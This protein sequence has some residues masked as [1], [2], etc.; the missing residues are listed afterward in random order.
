MKK[1][2]LIISWILKINI[3]IQVLYLLFF[4]FMGLFIG[5]ISLQDK[6]LPPEFFGTPSRFYWISSSGAIL[7]C[8]C[9]IAIFWFSHQL[10]NQGLR[11]KF[12]NSS[13]FKILR[14]LRI[15]IFLLIIPSSILTIASYDTYT[16]F[17]FSIDKMNQDPM[18]LMEEMY[19]QTFTDSLMNYFFIN[20]SVSTAIALGLIA[21]LFEHYLRENREMKNAMS[22]VI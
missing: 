11:E 8:L 16:S 4:S 2:L 10:I 1:V 18:K 20:F 12:P 22:E 13:T 5:Y 9:Y 15:S 6:I 14:S 21:L 17:K 3:A 7:S 19:G